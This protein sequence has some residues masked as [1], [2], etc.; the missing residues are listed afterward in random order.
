LALLDHFSFSIPAFSLF[1]KFGF[2]VDDKVVGGSFDYFWQNLFGD[3]IKQHTQIF[4]K[5][6]KP[7][8]TSSS[9]TLLFFSS[10]HKFLGPN[11]TLTRG[12]FSVWLC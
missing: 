6:I 12:H 2:G 11:K 10:F 8:L 7:F 9:K 4:H 3:L 1:V 5:A